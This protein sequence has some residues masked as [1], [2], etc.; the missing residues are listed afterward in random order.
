MLSAKWIKTL[1]KYAGVFLGVILFISLP[2]YSNSASIYPAKNFTGRAVETDDLGIL[3]PAGLAYSPVADMFFVVEDPVTKPWGLNVTDVIRFTSL[4][5]LVGTVEFPVAITNPA[6]MAFDKR[7]NRL[8]FYEAAT[9]ELIGIPVRADGSLDAAATIRI[10]TRHLGVQNPRGMT[11][12]PD[13]GS[14]FILD[15][16]ANL[17]IRI[18]PAPQDSFDSRG[19][20][21][22]S[23]TS[24][25][26]LAQIGPVALQ[27]IAFDAANGHL[28]LL[29]PVEQKIYELADTGQVISTYDISNFDLINPQ[30]MVL[31][32]SADPTD[33]PSE[34]SLFIA[35]TG[36][37]TQQNSAKPQQLGKIVELSF[38]EPTQMTFMAAQAA[39]ASTTCLIQTTDTSAFNP[40]SSDPAGLAYLSDQRGTILIS[41]SEIEEIS[42]YQGVN[43]F[44][45]TLSGV[46]VYTA[47]TTSYTN[48]PTG[49]AFNP[50]NGHLYFSDDDRKEIYEL[51]PGS[52]GLYGTN[53]DPPVTHFDTSV[54]SNGDPEG[55]AYGRINNQDYLFVADGVGEEVYIYNPGP[56]G[57]FGTGD[58]P[59]PTHFDV[60]VYGIGDP[61]GIEYDPIS[62]H[63][64]VLDSAGIGEIVETTINGTLI[65]TIDI[66]AASA[67]KPAG[68]TIAPGSANPGVMN[69]YISDRNI[70]NFN[71]G[72]VYELSFQCGGTDP[73]IS[74]TPSSLDYGDVERD[75][76][77]APQ[78]VTI[79]NVGGAD[80]IVDDITIGGGASS[81]FQITS[82]PAL[83]VTI[84]AGDSVP[85]EVIYSPLDLGGDS[86]TLVIDN[87][88]PDEPLVTVSL[89]GNGIDPLPDV[90]DIDVTP[91]TLDYGPV[92]R[93]GSSVRSVRIDNV[94]TL[95]LNVSD[96]RIVGNPSEFEITSN[97]SPVT[98]VVGDFVT[99]EVTYSPLDLGGDSDT[100]EIVSDDPDEP[101]VTVALSGSG[102]DIPPPGITFQEVQS[103][104]S[105][106]SNTVTTT[107]ADL[108]A[109]SGHLY[110]A[111]ISFKPNVTVSNVVGL[112]LNWTP[113]RAQCSGRSQTGVVVYMAQGTPSGDGAVTATLASAPANAIIV[114]SRYSGVDTV[115]SP[116]GN[117]VSGNTNGE[118]GGCSGG[119]DNNSHLFN[120]TTG[121]DGAVVYGAA[122]LRNRHYQPGAGYVRGVYPGRWRITG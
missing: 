14:L 28:Y 4:E 48:E 17:I 96:I 26:D 81:E 67:N 1:P 22:R 104:G 39:T 41:D 108:T 3:N 110:L 11:F 107:T 64:F 23:R 61:E 114:V 85:V 121:V 19:V 65:S 120:L 86:D 112:G 113:V 6:N 94:G 33:D 55:I 80:L 35:D 109:V 2:S 63:L 103:G 20:F 32:P 93:F 40:P 47:D 31:A 106:R 7:S 34:I 102:V 84:V 111:A 68:I 37:D 13:G 119:S 89:S 122:A 100:L 91:L 49:V 21:N 90:P 45:M 38:V 8:F 101:T 115:S 82:M 56:D 92:V 50:N 54:H 57:D 74:V 16:S 51:D 25:V 27:G 78:T 10:K 87:R 72:L 43:L 75:T 118:D 117:M 99:V 58:D 83:P 5:E 12:D 62:G 46:L 105:S 24:Y 66:S 29:S 73:D 79:R 60:G 36:I 18:E 15:S 30:S 116:I 88:D 69:F 95:D 71:D 9:N 52:D 98:I 44:E 70:D 42:D 53:D 97:P 59:A 76:S 77:S